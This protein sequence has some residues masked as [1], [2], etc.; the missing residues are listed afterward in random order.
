MASLIVLTFDHEGHPIQFDTWLDDLQLYLLRDS[1]ETVSLFDHTSGASLAP[2]ATADSATRSHW[3]IRD[4]ASRLAVRNHLPLAECAHFGQHKTDKALYDGVV[5][6]YSSPATAAL[7]CHIPPYIFPELD[8]FLAL[9][10]TDLTVDLLEKHHLAAETSVVTVGAARGTPRTPF[11][12]GCPPSLLDPSYASAATVDILGTEDVR[13]AF[14]SGNRHSGKGKGG[15]SGGGGSRGGGGKGSGG[16][17]GGGGGGGSGGGSGG[18]GGNGGGSGGSGGGGGGGSGSSGG[19]NG[20]G[21]ARPA[22]QRAAAAHGATAAMCPAEQRCPGRAAPPRPSRPP[23]SNAAAAARATAA[24]G[25]GAAG[26]AE[27][28]AAQPHRGALLLLLLLL[29]LV[30]PLLLEEVRLGLQRLG[31]DRNGHCLSRT[32][33]P[34]S[35][36]VSGLFSEVVLRY[37]PGRVEAAALGSSETAVATGAGESAATLGARESADALG[38]SASTA[39]GPASA[40][41]LHI[42]TL[43]SS[44]SC[45]FFRDCTIVTPLAAPVPALL[46]DPTGGPPGSGLYTLTTA[47]SHVAESGQVAASSQVSASGQLAASCSCRVLSHQTLL[48]HH[49]LG[50]PSLSRLRSM[51]SRLLVSSLPRSLPSLPRSPAPPCLPSVK[52]RQRDAPHSSEIP[53]TTAPLHILHMDVWGP[54]PVGGTDEERYFLLVVD[55]YTCYTTVFPLRRKADV[56]GF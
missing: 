15:K 51:H 44:A 42:F 54:A 52:G 30:L 20:G 4:A 35:S 56:S 31:V 19:G 34:L 43:D 10:P 26:S 21:R 48:W 53:P 50:H 32:T 13:A 28:A 40:E 11:F 29:L 12:E 23:A 14:A 46:A 16:G 2:L 39:T 17:G 37:V 7:G 6:R 47:S 25:G 41:A 22:A 33:P 49:R 8:H 45:C 18:F 55:D 36:F 9:D 5:A 38:A 27:G 3:L 24:A 1:R